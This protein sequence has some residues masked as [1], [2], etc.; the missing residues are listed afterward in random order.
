MKNLKSKLRYIFSFVLVFVMTFACFGLT[1][2]GAIKVKKK[3][4]INFDKVLFANLK[5]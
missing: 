1:A 4:F 5:L 2:C 3:N